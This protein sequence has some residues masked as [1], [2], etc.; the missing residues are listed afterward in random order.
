MYN[1]VSIPEKC[2]TRFLLV[3]NVHLKCPV[4]VPFKDKTISHHFF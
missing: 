4:E 2:E 1:Q 3:R